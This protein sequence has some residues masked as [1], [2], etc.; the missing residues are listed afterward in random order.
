MKFFENI[1]TYGLRVRALNAFISLLN[2]VLKND[3]L[4]QTARHKRDKNL[5]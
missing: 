1:I 3:L 5:I 2:D 4:C